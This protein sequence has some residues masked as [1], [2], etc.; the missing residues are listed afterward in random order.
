MN[1]YHFDDFQRS[2]VSIKGGW[3]TI[4]P[5]LDGIALQRVEQNESI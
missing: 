4:L 2:H 3:R 1:N 5:V